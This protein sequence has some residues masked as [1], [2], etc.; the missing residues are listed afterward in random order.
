MEREG[1]AAGSGVAAAHFGCCV[2]CVLSWLGNPF[3][4]LSNSAVNPIPDLLKSGIFI[5]IL[6]FQL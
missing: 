5:G 3:G 2:C 1:K 6:F 4:I